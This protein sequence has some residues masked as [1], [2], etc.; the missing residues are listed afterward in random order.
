MKT[1]SAVKKKCC[2]SHLESP[3]SNKNVKLMGVMAVGFNRY[4]A[5]KKWFLANTVDCSAGWD[6]E[7]MEYMV[8]SPKSTS[9]H[10]QYCKRNK[11]NK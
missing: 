7:Y 3:K 11:K 2:Q 10:S 9:G 4:P 5:S 1:G 8:A 6:I